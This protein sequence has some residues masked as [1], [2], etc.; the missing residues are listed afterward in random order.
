M[1]EFLHQEWKGLL[2]L[3]YAIND[4]RDITDFRK[5]VLEYTEKIIPNKLSFFDLCSYYRSKRLYFDPVSL[6]MTVEQLKLYYEKFEELDYTNWMINQHTKSTAYRDSDFFT[7]KLKQHSIIYQ[8][9]LSPMGVYF[10]CGLSIVADGI[11]Y[12][13][14][15]LF[16]AFDD[17]DFTD[18]EIEILEYI[19][20]YIQ[21]WLVG[22]YPNGISYTGNQPQLKELQAR[23][24]LTNREDEIVRLIFSGADITQLSD[25][26][27]ITENTVHKH[28][29]NIYK[30]M[31]VSNR[32]QLNKL[33]NRI[34]NQ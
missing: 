9:W 19:L 10:S 29:A 27:F 8:E 17:G 7:D 13:T 28:I 2:D 20:R 16:R 23:Y 3:V 25:M 30:K 1:E 4:N 6:N 33:V 12:G 24:F 21:Q 22:F 18:K 15:T 5:T 32:T 11:P 14:M 31:G 26:L 34:F